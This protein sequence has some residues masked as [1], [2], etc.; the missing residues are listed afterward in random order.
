MQAILR[1]LGWLLCAAGLAIIA[2]HF[3]MVYMGLS[4]TLNLGDS[5]KFEF[6]LVPFWAV[7]LGAMAIGAICLALSRGAKK[8]S[9]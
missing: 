3:V 1:P 6:I 5:A 2:G 7:G 4:A 9:K 8:T